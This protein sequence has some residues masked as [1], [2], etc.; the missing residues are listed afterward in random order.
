MILIIIIL[1]IFGLFYIISYVKE[2]HLSKDPRIV[3]LKNK[4]SRAFPELNKAKLMKGNS[5]YTLNKH[6]VFICTEKN[7]VKYDDNMLTYVILHEL[8]HVLCDEVGHTPKF[9][10]IFA[11]L[12]ARAEHYG[13]YDPTLKRVANYCK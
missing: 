6:K 2:E 8:A 11:G 9:M 3:G 4:L 5:S 13:L 10:E 1:I 12:L 7:G